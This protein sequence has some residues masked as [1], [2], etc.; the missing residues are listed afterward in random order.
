MEL[1]EVPQLVEPRNE[2]IPIEPESVF[3]ARTIVQDTM[4]DHLD[5]WRRKAIKNVGKEKA[6]Q[7]D[8]DLIPLSLNGAIS[9]AL[10]EAETEEE[11]L[12]IFADTYLGYP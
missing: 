4:E 11:V 3:E 12:A 2:A 7:F 6:S 8:S 1:E 5:K 9:G 10:E